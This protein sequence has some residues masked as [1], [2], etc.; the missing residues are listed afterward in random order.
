MARIAEIMI[1][2]L[3]E[4]HMLTIRRTINFFE[5]YTDFMGEAIRTILQHIEEN[6][7][8]PSSGPIVCFYNMDLENLAVEIGFVTP[9]PIEPS[10]AVQSVTLP[11]RKVALTI[12]RGPYEEQ[13]PTLEAL[14]KWIPEH[15]YE[16]CGGIYYHYLNGEDQPEQE[17]LTEMFLP[18]KSS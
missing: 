8:W 17:Y 18:I 16:A 12:D 3:P 7:A 2:Q 9:R 14:M 15:G 5:E 13:D 1:K 4:Q 11:I 6:E 10:N